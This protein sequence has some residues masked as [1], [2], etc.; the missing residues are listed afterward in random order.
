MLMFV[1]L[2]ARAP[3]TALEGDMNLPPVDPENRAR[4]VPMPS[5]HHR[6]R[7]MANVLSAL[8]LGV[9]VFFAIQQGL[10][11]FGSLNRTEIAQFAL[12][13]L[14]L[15]GLALCW[16]RTLPGALLTLGAFAGFWAVNL[17]ATG[18]E[19]LGSVYVLF[20]LAGAL[21]LAAWWAAR[22]ARGDR[23]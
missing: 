19:R 6:L 23:H 18:G 21:Q 8:V 7:L 11:R 3:R 14:M 4:S 12:F 1:A 5:P 22:S 16:F 2:P 15:A 17:S 10:P 20:P 9:A 13:L